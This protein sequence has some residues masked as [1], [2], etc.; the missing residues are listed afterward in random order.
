MV[1]PGW[2]SYCL[3]GIEFWGLQMSSRTL[4]CGQ[5]FSVTQNTIIN[6]QSPYISVGQ[7]IVI[8]TCPYCCFF[9]PHTIL[10]LRQLC[11]LL[12][13]HAILASSSLTESQVVSFKSSIFY[14]ELQEYSVEMPAFCPRFFSFCPPVSS[15]L[16]E[17]RFFIFLL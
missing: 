17:G 16:D 9:S 3:S 5:S 10:F 15:V 2:L 13:G 1:L 4:V 8:I 14:Q 7:T 6:E 12:K 11:L